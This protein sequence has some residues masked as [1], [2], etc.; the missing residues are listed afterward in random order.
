MESFDTPKRVS[1]NLVSPIPVDERYFRPPSRPVN[2]LT[3]PRSRDSM[4][5]ASRFLSGGTG[6][7]M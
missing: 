4:L 5:R 1:E 2:M 7:R 6:G 3:E